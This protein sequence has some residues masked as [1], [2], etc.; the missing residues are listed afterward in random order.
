MPDRKSQIAKRLAEEGAKAA[1]YMRGLESAAWEQQVY[2]TGG[3]WRVREVLCHFVSTEAALQ[4]YG[5]DILSGGMG[6]PEDFV[7]D[8]Y[9]ETQ[10]G[11]MAERS[12][13][14]LIDEFTASRAATLAMVAGMADA[15]FER[16]GRHPWFGRAPLEDMLK[17]AYRHTMI[18]LRD[19]RRALETGQPV[20]HLDVTPPAEKERGERKGSAEGA[21]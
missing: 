13:A 6:A 18:H 2:L 15:D 1:E 7:I 9:N 17:L 11:G 21:A 8:E 12:P 3:L 16:I 10:V 5:Q 14:G 19:V 20:P 4:K